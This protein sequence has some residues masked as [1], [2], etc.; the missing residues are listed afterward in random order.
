MAI[1]HFCSTSDHFRQ[2][3]YNY[4]NNA[5]QLKIKRFAQVIYQTLNAITYSQAPRPISTPWAPLRTGEDIGITD[6]QPMLLN[7][8]ARNLLNTMCC[9]WA[10]TDFCVFDEVLRLQ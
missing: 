10:S 7:C 8:T 1:T 2:V 4:Q 6:A 5:A 9:R 3:E